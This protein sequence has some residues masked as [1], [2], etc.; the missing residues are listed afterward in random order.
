MV[1]CPRLQETLLH[2]C[3]FMWVFI[4]KIC[5]PILY[6]QYV[7]HALPVAPSGVKLTT[8]GKEYKL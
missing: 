3:S 1:L 6:L 8:F 4:L 7:L 2:N 5:V